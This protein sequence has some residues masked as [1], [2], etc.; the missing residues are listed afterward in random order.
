LKPILALILASIGAVCISQHL[1]AETSSGVVI[2]N[3]GSAGREVAASASALRSTLA[4]GRS[5]L[6]GNGPEHP[7]IPLDQIGAA[8]M[9]QYSGNGLSVCAT[10]SGARLRCLFQRLEGDVT[11][12]GLRLT[13]TASDTIKARFRVTAVSVTRSADF[14]SAV[15]PNCIRQGHDYARGSASGTSSPFKACDTAFSKNALDLQPTGTVALD[16]QTVRFT[17]PGL[18]E[19]YSVSMDGVRQDFIIQRRLEGEGELRVELAVTGAKAEPL[20]DGAR[21]V[22]N[23]SRRKIAYSRL[24]VTDAT[25]KELP[26]R[27]E[28]PAK[29]EI[30][31]PKSETSLAV[32]V[33][34]AGAGYPLRID[35]TFSDANWISMGGIPGANGDVRATVVDGSG[36]LYIGGYFTVVGETTAN[37]IARWDGSSWSA[38][39]SGMNDVVAAMA[40]SGS[41]LYA[42]GVF[43]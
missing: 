18:T 32:V 42:G 6:S 37:H 8:A 29:S 16:G 35:P 40:V 17:R 25:G 14:Q 43:T 28:V 9:K 11:S 33:N 41:D 20:V 15:S 10:E 2:R 30:Q 13:S 5:T 27:M 36:N 38:L 22:L 23:A 19:E 34:D 7:S 24:R 12:K 31:N 4:Q 21:M 39:G 3:V 1:P 26:A